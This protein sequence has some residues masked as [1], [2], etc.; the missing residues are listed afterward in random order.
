MKYIHFPYF[1]VA[2]AIGLFM[3]YITSPEAKV[4][5]VYPTPQNVTDIQ[6]KDQA[7][8]CYQ[9]KATKT[10]CTN[11]AKPIPAQV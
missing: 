6:Y 3:N 7:D 4:I 9:F 11:N 10:K 2:L 5:Y 1:I 8:N